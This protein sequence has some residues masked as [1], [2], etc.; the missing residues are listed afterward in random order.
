MKIRT[1]FVTNSSSSSFSLILTVRGVDGSE[2]NYEDFP[3]WEDS[4]EARFEG[5]LGLLS[6]EYV[7]N[8]LRENADQKYKL[9]NDMDAKARMVA[10]M[11]GDELRLKKESRSRFTNREIKS[12]IVECSA[13]ELGFLPDAIAQMVFPVLNHPGIII[14]A[15]ACKEKPSGPCTVKLTASRKDGFTDKVLAKDVSTLARFLM[16]SSKNDYGKSNTKKKD[17]FSAKMGKQFTSLDQIKSITVER[18]YSGSGEGS[19]MVAENDQELT[20]LAE[21]VVESDGEEKKQAIKKMREYVSSPNAHRQKN[22]LIFGSGF[23]DFRYSQQTDDSSLLRIARRLCSGYAPDSTDGVEHS[24][25]NLLTGESRNYAVFN[26]KPY[27]E[28]DDLG[29]A[30]EQGLRRRLAQKRDN[31]EKRKRAI[32]DAW[33]KANSEV[34]IATPDIVFTD[35]IF[36]FAG[37]MAEE[38]LHYREITTERGG[39]VRTSVSGKTDYLIV[40]PCWAADYAVNCAV[41]QQ[42]KGKKVQII[43]LEHFSKFLK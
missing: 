2:V 18:R 14:K 4:G 23:D 28:G 34:S 30:S 15:T 33:M 24:E 17:S 9:S 16:E 6:V 37:M 41:E 32:K 36:V 43:L 39:I 13:G 1:D 8:H 21:R 42:K 3:H 40:E 20:A 11:D 26:L 10:I 31:E 12:V 35:H 19:Q 5:N 25:I 27:T 22:G 29:D 38:L 7:L